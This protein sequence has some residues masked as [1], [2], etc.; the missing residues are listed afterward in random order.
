[1]SFLD[2]FFRY[3]FF[4]NILPTFFG[5]IHRRYKK[6]GKDLTCE[7]DFAMYCI[8]AGTQ[9][10]VYIDP[11]RPIVLPTFRQSATRRVIQGIKQNSVIHNIT[12]QC[13]AVDVGDPGRGVPHG[14]R[15]HR[16]ILDTGNG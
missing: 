3:L 10:I 6:A 5:F 14:P 12:E 7:I 16:G 15:V 2:V 1:M 4:G 13:Q 11:S 9:R 8:K